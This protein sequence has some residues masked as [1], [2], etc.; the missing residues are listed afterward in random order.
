[1]VWHITLGPERLKLPSGTEAKMGESA[2][3]SLQSVNVCHN[4][5]MTSSGDVTSIAKE[6]LLLSLTVHVV[7]YEVRRWS[8]SQGINCERMG[9]SSSFFQGLI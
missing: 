2:K 4:L 1:M 9:T 7:W 8:E 5:G 3:C 6:V